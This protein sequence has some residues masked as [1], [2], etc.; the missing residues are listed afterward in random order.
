MFILLE[1]IMISM[2]YHIGVFRCSVSLQYLMSF[3]GPFLILCYLF[4][5]SNLSSKLEVKSSCLIDRFLLWL[6]LL[7]E[8]SIEYWSDSFC[9]LSESTCFWWPFF[10]SSIWCYIFLEKA[11]NFFK[12]MSERSPVKSSSTDELSLTWETDD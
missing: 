7:S 11:F 2:T 12:G 3:G 6:V 4:T 1:N 9:Y 10:K 8:F 5:Y